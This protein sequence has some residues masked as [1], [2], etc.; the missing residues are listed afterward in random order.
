MTSHIERRANP[1]LMGGQRRQIQPG[2]GHVQTLL[3]LLQEGFYLLFMLKNGSMPP[4]E[5]TFLD[6]ITAYLAEFDRDARKG[7]VGAVEADGDNDPG[8]PQ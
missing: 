1:T 3:D 5:A 4:E 7:Q 6:T 8:H 2:Y